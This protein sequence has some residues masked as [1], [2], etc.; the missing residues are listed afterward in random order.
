MGLPRA[1]PAP[2]NGG[3]DGPQRKS[4]AHEMGLH[5]PH[6]VDPEVQEEG[7]VWQGGDGGKRHTGE[8]G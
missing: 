4:S 6:S 2:G 8:A 5:L 3:R 1:R 7:A